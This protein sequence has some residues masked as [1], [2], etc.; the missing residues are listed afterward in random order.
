VLRDQWQLDGC[1]TNRNRY[2]RNMLALVLAR[3]GDLTGGIRE[4]S[5]ALA[6]DRRLCERPTI[7][8]GTMTSQLGGM[9][10]EAGRF[11]EGLAELDRSESIIRAAGGAAQRLPTL[12]RAARR[13]HCL[14]IA[15]RAAE[16][17]ELAVDILGQE[18]FAGT[19]SVRVGALRSMGRLSEAETHVS[20]M[21]DLSGRPG[22]DPV[23]RARADLEAAQLRLAQG[24]TAKGLVYARR[25]LEALTPTQVPESALL[26]R[27][28]DL[29]AA[30]ELATAGAAPREMPAE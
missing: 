4:I 8:T 9:L 11:D 7:D 30:C 14:L 19:A 16:A 10:V 2:T 23:I 17:L 1:D 27:A 29:V 6:A 13:A 15:G 12:L 18:D 22:T 21:M 5:D 28:R 20:A 26:H 3:R 25:A 24:R